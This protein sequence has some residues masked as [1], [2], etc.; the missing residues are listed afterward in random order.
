LAENDRRPAF[1]IAEVKRTQ[2]AQLLRR[3]ILDRKVVKGVQLSP[4]AIAC[5][6]LVPLL[7]GVQYAVIKVGLTAFPPFFFVGL[8]F[9]AIAAILLPFVERPIRREIG[10]IV[11]ISIF[12]GGL[13]FGLSFAGLEHG[14]AGV[15]SI[16]NQLSSPFMVLLGWPILGERPTVRVAFGVALAFGGVALLMIEPGAAVRLVPTLLVMGAGLA[17]AVG[18]VLTKRFG[19]FEPLKL[20]AWM[21]LLTVPQAFL[22]SFLLEK[23]QV[24]SL[25]AATPLDWLPFP[26]TVALGGI[27]GYGLWF[28]LIAKY[29]MTQ[30]APYALLQ[31]VFAFGAGLLF[32]GERVTWSLVFGLSVCMGGVAITQTKSRQRLLLAAT[33]S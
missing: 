3:L 18:S 15:S 24:A 29:S 21:A 26:Y 33:A 20:M 2:I 23:G 31:T 17:L 11:G 16:V 9:A 1:R 6:L 5:A 7:W 28:W 12:L 32:L 19:P 8:R 10:P 22:T 14:P 27:A 4:F 25:F 30:V 13:N